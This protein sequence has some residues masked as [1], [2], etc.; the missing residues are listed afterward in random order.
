MTRAER[1][2]RSLPLWMLR[3]V[4]ALGCRRSWVEAAERELWHRSI[5][6]VIAETTAE[7]ESGPWA[8]DAPKGR[9]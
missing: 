7:D 9:Q 6:G 1:I 5:E 4:A 3:Q 2:C 8:V